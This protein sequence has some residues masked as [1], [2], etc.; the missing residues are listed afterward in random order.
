MVVVE[1]LA[2]P[3]RCHARVGGMPSRRVGLRLAPHTPDASELFR[4]GCQLLRN[5]RVS[6]RR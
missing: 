1:W 2:I 6:E 5:N 4:Q 3:V